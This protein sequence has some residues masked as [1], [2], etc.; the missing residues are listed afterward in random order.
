MMTSC[1]LPEGDEFDLELEVVDQVSQTSHGLAAWPINSRAQSPQP[2]PPAVAPAGSSVMPGYF[3]QL[4][5]YVPV[6]PQPALI[7]RQSHFTPPITP[8]SPGWPGPSKAYFNPSF[9][10][11]P[12]NVSVLQFL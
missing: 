4:P 7:N 10:V 5:T 3:H 8:F 9:E 1:C 12:Y 2:P 6:P 11:L